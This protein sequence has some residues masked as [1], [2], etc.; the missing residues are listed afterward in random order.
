MHR[1][2]DSEFLDSYSIDSVGEYN[3][4]NLENIIESDYRPSPDKR[5]ASNKNLSNNITFVNA[6]SAS[7]K[8]KTVKSK[9]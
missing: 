6:S 8:T 2:F 9:R 3:F 1:R 5:M 4:S 7:L